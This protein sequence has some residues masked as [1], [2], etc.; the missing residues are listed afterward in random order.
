MGLSINVLNPGQE[1]ELKRPEAGWMSVTYGGVRKVAILNSTLLVS[2]GL[3]LRNRRRRWRLH[4]ARETRNGSGWRMDTIT[5]G[6]EPRHVPPYLTRYGTPFLLR[7]REARPR[8]HLSLR[9][10]L[11]PNLPLTDLRDYTF[12]PHPPTLKLE[13]LPL[14][15]T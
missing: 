5:T 10:S 6:A 15:L 9:S 4:A 11:R 3:S 8:S 13:H 1:A 7:I 12:L 14:F 2:P